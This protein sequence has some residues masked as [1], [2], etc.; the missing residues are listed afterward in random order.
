M[1]ISYQSAAVCKL[2][3]QALPGEALTS[4]CSMY[5]PAIQK[6]FRASTP[7]LWKI[8]L[9]VDTCKKYE[10][11]D[12]LFNYL[13]QG[14]AA[15]YNK[16][17]ALATQPAVP[18]RHET[19]AEQGYAEIVFAG[20]FADFTIELQLAAIEALAMCLNISSEQISVLKVQAGTIILQVEMPAAA[21]KRLIDM[22]Q[23]HDPLIHDLGVQHVAQLDRRTAQTGSLDDF[24]RSGRIRRIGSRQTD[25]LFNSMP[26]TF[27][28]NGPLKPVQAPADSTM[29]YARPVR[30]KDVSTSSDNLHKIEAP[31]AVVPAVTAL[32][33]LSG[34]VIEA[35]KEPH[36]VEAT[37]IPEP[38]LTSLALKILYFGG[39]LKGWQVAQAMRL[40]FSGVVEPILQTLRQHHLVQVT[41]GSNL[42]RA[43]YQY[44]ITDKGS[45]RAR[46]LLERNR[47]VGPC[48]VTLPH[49]IQV[50][51]LQAR[52]RPV[53]KEGAVRRVLR[54]L[55]LP[56]EVIDRI[57][58]AVNSFKSMFLY[59]PPGNGKTSIAKA[60]GRGLLPGNIMVPYA[61]YESGQVITVFDRETHRP[62]VS[63][64]A[65]LAESNGLD[66]RWVRCGPPVVV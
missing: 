58:P 41:G 23:S 53:I 63:E 29:T 11:F 21:V 36:T 6:K 43:S 12:Q 18:P 8:Q 48:P 65:Q 31:S 52:G 15:D 26:R 27:E 40:H 50:V 51:K 7:R 55:V 56:P 42:N 30:L 20:D 57:G 33:V 46:E 17:V 60:I 19:A 14:K 13:A 34:A 24:R 47:Y 22:V 66:K 37:G 54:G 9:L 35:I 25:Q 3:N 59:G 61:L 2:L 5:F 32:E 16:F 64:E 38:F 62:E 4:F 28:Q 1:K 10:Q 45:G 44:I 39:T 49:Y